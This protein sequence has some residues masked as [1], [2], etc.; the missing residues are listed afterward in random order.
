MSGFRL[1]GIRTGKRPTVEQIQSG[2]KDYFKILKEDTY[3]PFYSCFSYDQD[4]HTL[5]Y[6]PDKDVDLYNLLDKVR[7][8]GSTSISISAVVG[9]NGTGKSTLLELLY[10]AAYHAGVAGGVLIHPETEQEITTIGAKL[11]VDLEV[12]FQEDEMSVTHITLFNL[13]TPRWK[14]YSLTSDPQILELTDLAQTP[15]GNNGV[16]AVEN[17]TLKELFYSI[18]VNYSIYGLNAKTI[19]GWINHL[20]HK[21]DAY[22]THSCD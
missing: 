9:K 6:H 7:R 22:Q 10:L 12:F 15:L 14:K 2:R 17:G 5:T 16:E 13:T 20:F 21:N 1:L 18:A 4:T 8:G 19:G 11:G 3:Y